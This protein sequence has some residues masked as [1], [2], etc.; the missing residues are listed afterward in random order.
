M[1]LEMSRY[2]AREAEA[3]RVRTILE[4][5]AEFARRAKEELAQ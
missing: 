1:S 5:A 3:L 4:I 2:R